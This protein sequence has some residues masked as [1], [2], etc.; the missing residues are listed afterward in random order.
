[1]AS[2]YDMH[3]GAPGMKHFTFQAIEPKAELQFASY[4]RWDLSTVLY[5]DALPIDVGKVEMMDVAAEGISI[6][7]RG[8]PPFT[9]PSAGSRICL[10][11]AYH[12]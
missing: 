8:W 11:G 12:D 2:S 1:M 7:Y 9:K 3:L 10:P 5:K 6:R 4:R